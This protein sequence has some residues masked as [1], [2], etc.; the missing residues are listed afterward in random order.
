MNCQFNCQYSLQGMFFNCWLTWFVQRQV[1]F[2]KQRRPVIYVCLGQASCSN[3]TVDDTVIHMTHLFENAKRTMT[4]DTSTWIFVVDCTGQ[5]RNISNSYCIVF[6]IAFSCTHFASRTPHPVLP[7]R[8]LAIDRW[9]QQL[10][11]RLYTQR[12]APVAIDHRC[13]KLTLLR[14]LPSSYMYVPICT[15]PYAPSNK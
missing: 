8:I 13:C 2:D 12:C 1:G 14:W 15:I 11:S 3:T 7:R 10:L 4:G 5:W 9:R 6:S